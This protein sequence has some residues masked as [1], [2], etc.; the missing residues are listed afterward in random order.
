MKKVAVIAFIALVISALT[1][2][3]SMQEQKRMNNR[4]TDSSMK[5]RSGRR[6]RSYNRKQDERQSIM[7]VVGEGEMQIMP[8]DEE[9]E[10]RILPYNEDGQMRALPYYGE[11]SD[12]QYQQ[13]SSNPSNVNNNTSASFRFSRP[14]R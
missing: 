10:M 14:N 13:F 7:P 1:T 3:A 6:G 12:M 2:H 9:N 8:Y 11:E 5:K 4:T